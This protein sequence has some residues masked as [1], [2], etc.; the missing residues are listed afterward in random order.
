MAPGQTRKNRKSGGGTRKNRATPLIKNVNAPSGPTAKPVLRKAV[1]KVI[2]SNLESKFAIGVPFNNATSSSLLNHTA[3]TSAITSTNEV[4]ALIPIVPQGTDD[5][6][7]TGQQ[8]EP[9]SLTTRVHVTLN[10]ANLSAESVYVDF[11]FVTSKVVKSF[12]LES[13]VPTSELLNSGDGSN[14]PYDGT[15]YTAGYP[16]NKSKFTLIK[17]KRVLLQKGANNPNNTL[18]GGATP[19]TDTFSYQKSFSVKIPLPKKLTYLNASETTPSN[20]YPFMMVGFHGS[21][22][23]GDSA[24]VN[25][26]VYV[27]AQSHLYYKDA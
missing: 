27:Q 14:V 15:S 4:Y 10:P 6:Q 12:Y 18:T 11:Y 2:K 13:Q 5:F 24:P 1:E 3:F 9:R 21:D 25:P 8:I 16:I 7:R 19:A 26:R 17:H 22:T 23:T 20:Y